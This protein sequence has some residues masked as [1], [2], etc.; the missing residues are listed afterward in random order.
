MDNDGTITEKGTGALSGGGVEIKVCRREVFAV[1]NVH[2]I[3]IFAAQI[4]N[5][6]CIWPGF[7]TGRLLAALE[8]IKMGKSP[9]AVAIRGDRLVMD[10]VDWHVLC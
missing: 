7:I 1:C 8:W 9:A 3:S 10:V 2:D 6:A 4:A 5:L